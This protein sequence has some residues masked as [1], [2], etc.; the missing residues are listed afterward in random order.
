MARVL[1]KQVRGVRDSKKI[2][3]EGRMKVGKAASF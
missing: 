3:R 2:R 1:Q